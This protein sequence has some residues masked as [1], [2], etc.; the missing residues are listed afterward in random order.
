MQLKIFSAILFV[1]TLTASAQEKGTLKKKPISQPL[2]KHIF[3]ADPSAHVFN[4]KIYIYPSHDFEAGIKEDDLGSHFGMRDYHILSMDSVGGKVT[5]NGI[6][7][8]IKDVPWAGRQMWAPDAAYKDG[9]YY[10][11]FPVKDKN[12]VFHIGV[13]TSK[14]PAGPF[15][16]EKEPIKGSYSIDPAVFKDSDGSY[17]M[18]F[19][20][21]W[22]GQLQRWDNNKYTADAKLKTAKEEAIL[23][24]V[25]KLSADMKSFVEAPRNIKIV[26]ANGKTFLESN[27]DKRFFEAAWMHK[28]KG[29]YY[30]S[31]ST[32]DS[33]FINYA[34]GTNP[35]GPFTYKGVVLNPVEGWTNHHS[36]VE[37]KGKWYLFYHDTQISGKTHLRNVKV[38]ELKYNADGTIQT[39]NA[40]N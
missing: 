10:L 39:I 36:I 33:H 17:Y 12:D 29:K 18:Y 5:D 1:S 31:Y 7:L 37:V 25:A 23:P 6:A 8:D 4:G 13:A 20:G 34:T 11:Y 30:F 15:K 27:N 28:Y 14:K 40:Y 35:Y 22:G 24:R 26:D 3:T 21:I 32:G 16:A 38:T 19:G 9:T 2:V